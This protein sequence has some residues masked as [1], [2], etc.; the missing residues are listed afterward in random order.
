[1]P[2]VK[3]SSFDIKSFLERISLD[4]AHVA[5]VNLDTLET[6]VTAMTRSVPFE[7][8]DVAMGRGIDLNTTFEKI[9]VQRRGGY[10]FEINSLL[11]TALAALGFSTRRSLCRVLLGPRPSSYT[12]VVT[13]VTLGSE[14]FLVDTG[15]GGSSPRRPLPLASLTAQGHA[16][17]RVGAPM[18]AY[19]DAYRFIEDAGQ[20]VVSGGIRLQCFQ[21]KVWVQEGMP[22]LSQSTDA[23]QSCWKDQYVFHPEAPAFD[24][25]IEIGNWSQQGS[26]PGNTWLDFRLAVLFTEH[27]RKI[28]RNGRFSQ[29]HRASHIDLAMLFPDA[30][31]PTPFSI[32]SAESGAC[33]VV[34]EEE[35]VCYGDWF[36]KLHAEFGIDLR[37]DHRSKERRPVKSRADFEPCM[38]L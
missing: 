21:S 9:V 11:C 13:I 18:L 19:P 2:D 37:W 4:I 28:L 30:L 7:N 29:E 12:H 15:F 20:H 10:C 32:A 3:E 38:R 26:M 31:L 6:L 33:P 1:M 8:L 22:D 23:S 25:D 36:R 34:C 5:N 17:S 35:D 27:G 16:S 24:S 14:D